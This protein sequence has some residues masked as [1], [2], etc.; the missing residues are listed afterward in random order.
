MKKVSLIILIFILNLFLIA[1]S[2]RR[3]MVC[4][5]YNYNN[6]ISIRE[7]KK[8]NVVELPVEPTRNKYTFDGWYTDL[9][10]NDKYD[11]NTKITSNTTIYAKWTANNTYTIE[12]ELNGGKFE[13]SYPTS[14]VDPFDVLLPIPYKENYVFDGW[15]END[16]K[17]EV[18]ADKDYYLIAKYNPVYKKV[19]PL[20]I[21]PIRNEAKVL[22]DV[23]YKNVGGE[24]VKMDIYLPPLKAN[25]TC[26]A[27]FMYYG[28][29]FISGDKSNV[30]TSNGNRGYLQDIF[31]YALD[32]KIA[33]IIPNYRLANGNTM[34][35]PYPVEDALDA[36]RFCVKNSA[37]LGIDVNNMGSIGYSAGAYMALMSAF[38]SDYFYGDPD[39]RVGIFRLKYVVDL[40]GPAYFDNEELSKLSIEAKYMLS[41]FFG[42]IDYLDTSINSNTM[43]SFYVNNNTPS[44]LI[45]HGNK[46]S[47][48]PC[49]QSIKFYDLLQSKKITS[50]YIEVDNAEHGFVLKDNTKPLNPNNDEI[51]QIIEKFIIDT[52][53]N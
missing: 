35:F 1:C 27:L 36:I 23:T 31:D 4:F 40:F 26:P 42:P 2:N 22:L 15:Y 25:E 44:V 46:D 43:P 47:L 38:A 7:V 11:E 24:S 18:L 12:Y 34:T 9:S 39:L 5:D 32:N 41:C 3:Y 49:S 8:G 51:I 17:I 53:N 30:A 50:R 37:V 10:L 16:N 28:G 48:V 14:F 20:T 21:S 13:G 52:I 6:I 29:G 19:D 45:L 33:V